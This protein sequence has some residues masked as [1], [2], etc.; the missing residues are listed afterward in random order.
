MKQKI[1]CNLV[2]MQTIEN[3]RELLPSFPTTS[4]LLRFSDITARAKDAEA[5][6]PG[7]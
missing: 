2:L 1:F 6:T 3:K 4:L 5:W 7:F